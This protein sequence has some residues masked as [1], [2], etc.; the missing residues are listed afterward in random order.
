MTE[1]DVKKQILEQINKDIEKKFLGSFEECKEWMTNHP[2]NKP[3]ILVSNRG[4][5]LIIIY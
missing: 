3:H 5:H 4:E 1:I 2:E